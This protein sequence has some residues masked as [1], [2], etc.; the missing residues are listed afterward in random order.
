MDRVTLEEKVA[1][2]KARRDGL[3][4][5][6]QAMESA[7][8]KLVAQGHQLTGAIGMAEELLKDTE[9]VNRLTPDPSLNAEEKKPAE[10]LAG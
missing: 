8:V 3:E 1:E 4:K 7:R 6:L 5:Q 9:P 2:M 10:S